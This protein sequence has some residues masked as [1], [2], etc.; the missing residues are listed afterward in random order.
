MFLQTRNSV[1]E[2]GTSQTPEFDEGL[3]GLKA[4]EE[5]E[6][7]FSFPSDYHAEDLA[8]KEAI[9]KV[10][11]SGVKSLALPELDEEFAKKLGQ[12]SL[13][14]LKKLIEENILAQKEG[15][16]RQEAH[17]KAVDAIL[18]NNDFEVPEARIRSFAESV[19]KKEEVSNDEIENVRSE[20]TFEIKKHRILENISKKEKNQSK[21]S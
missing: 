3:K 15:Q 12:E 4:G 8:G 14:A 2:I 16:A 10:S 20:A 5:K 13:E 1:V 21:T 18:E 19:L 6:I 11:I 7:K 9:Y 17:K